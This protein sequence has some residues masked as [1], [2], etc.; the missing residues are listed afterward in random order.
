M[1]FV[2]TKVRIADN[3]GGLIG[4][5]IRVCNVHKRRYGLPG[6]VIVVSIRSIRPGKKIKKGELYRAVIVR[7]RKGMVR[8][9]SECV[10][11]DD[12]SVV[13]VNKKGNPIATRVLGPVMLELKAKGFSNVVSLAAATV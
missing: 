13:L 2:G 7:S 1:I 5:C 10:R 9:G 6:E 8:R 12:N 4:K 11:C 3:S